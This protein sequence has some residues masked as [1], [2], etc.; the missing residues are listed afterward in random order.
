VGRLE[1]KT[2]ASPPS[3]PQ[4][5]IGPLLRPMLPLLA[6]DSQPGHGLAS[7]KSASGP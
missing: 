7:A 2:H 6:F 1:V 4:I 5:S 3:E